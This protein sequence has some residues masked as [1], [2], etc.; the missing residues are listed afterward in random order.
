MISNA[1]VARIMLNISDRLSYMDR[2]EEAL[3]AVEDAVELRRKLAREEP[4]SFN[5]DLAMSLNNLFGCLSKL[6]RR[7]DALEAI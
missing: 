4:T 1:D 7:E 3:A 5:P 6:G 2:R